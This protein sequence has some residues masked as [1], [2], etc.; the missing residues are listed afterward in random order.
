MKIR[1]RNAVLGFVGLGI[2]AAVAGGVGVAQAAETDPNPS[3]SATARGPWSDHGPGAH[4]MARGQGPVLTAAATYLG[5][6]QE[7]LLTQLRAGKSLADIASEKGKSVSGL[8]DAILA[9][10]K[11]RLDA[12]TTLTAEQKTACLERA[13]SRVD[14]MINKA[15]T[16]GSGWA[17]WR[18][19]TNGAQR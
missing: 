12:N 8:R 9:A 1:R 16:P 19:R 5:V 15:H 17:R 14:T 10:V 18:G 6:S 13:K 2:A 7:D 11:S 3:P 4:A